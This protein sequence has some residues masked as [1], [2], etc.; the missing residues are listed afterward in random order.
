MQAEESIDI[1]L[2]VINAENPIEIAPPTEPEEA[3]MSLDQVWS[4]DSL[5]DE[6]MIAV[7]P[8]DVHGEEATD[9]VPEG[10]IEVADD[11]MDL[12][13][14]VLDETIQP[15]NPDFIEFTK[16]ENN[17]NEDL[18]TIDLGELIGPSTSSAEP[19]VKIEPID[20]EDPDWTSEP[21]PKKR[22][23]GRP[24]LPR[25]YPEP[26]KYVKTVQ[27]SSPKLTK[28]LFRRPRGRPPTASTVA[29]IHEYENSSAMS[30]ED[31]KL[32]KYRRMRDLNN[33]ASKR[34]RVN[35]KL[36]FDR[37]EHELTNL[38]TRNLKL[39]NEV[40]SLEERVAKAKK[41]IFAMVAKKQNNVNNQPQAASASVLSSFDL[42]AFVNAEIDKH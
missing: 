31:Q 24:R 28:L 4:G 12:L 41:I 14:F 8:Y 7:N 42:D 10:P 22:G 1:V 2:P 33:A 25:P 11:D 29:I 17:E 38:Q 13:K 21:L 35:R 32:V 5:F 26:A 34:C 15:D 27:N 20:V 39:K 9:E 18:S 36:K 23:R 30:E 6:D 19:E 16:T 37:Q 3:K 40:E